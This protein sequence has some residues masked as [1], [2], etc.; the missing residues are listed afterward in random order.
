VSAVVR[1]NGKRVRVLRGSRLRSVV[2]L[3]GLPVGRFTV[4]VDAKDAAGRHYRESRSYHPCR[5]TPPAG[6]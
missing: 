3:R 1:V 5:H 2:D 6:A 4:S